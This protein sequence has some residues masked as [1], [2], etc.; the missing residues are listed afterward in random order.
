MITVPAWLLSILVTIVGN[1]LLFA[2]RW[3]RVQGAMQTLTDKV[4]AAHSRID[5]LE[6]E[7][8]GSVEK[9]LDKVEQK[10]T[11]LEALDEAREPSR[12]F[13]TH[14]RDDD[15]PSKR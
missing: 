3:G 11:R 9:D 8:L 10:V 2:V 15:T 1:A 5:A 12:I 14:K 13:K 4:T 6:K 7:R